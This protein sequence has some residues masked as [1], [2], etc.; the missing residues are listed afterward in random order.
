[1]YKI[2]IDGSEGTTGLRIRERLAARSE[3]EIF[4]L[5]EEKRKSPDARREAIAQSDI[6]F[7]CLP[8]EAAI[9]SAQFAQGT[10][11]RVIDAST[12]HRT[13]PDWS[14]GFPELSALHREK[15]IKGSRVAVP[16]CHA[17]GLIALVYPLIT[18]GIMP[19]DYPV[20][21]FSLTGYSGGGK[22]MIAQYQSAD[23]AAEFDSPRQYAL[24]QKHK[25]LAEMSAVTGLAAPPVFCPIVGDFYS[26]ME[27]TVPIFPGLLSKKI[28][29]LQITEILAEHYE[30]SQF[31]K[32]LPFSGEN[33]FAAAAAYSGL[34]S[35][36][37]SVWGN[38]ER[39][40]LM[41]RYDNL[42]KGAS[43]AA[44]QCMNLMLGLP[45][46]AGLAL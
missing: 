20:S 43:G 7:L 13:K 35:M 39:I 30:S 8:D 23:R 40:I 45:E 3:L 41:A 10:S 6:S 22:K 15:V 24:A 12:A 26:G 21:C 25:H 46:S 5:P 44:I 29:P 31:I 11:A 19:A 37:L 1:M 4:V 36:E 28:S 17:S 27:V 38:D 32:V 33:A 9:E 2:F 16:G 14:Y 18:A 34:D 42:G